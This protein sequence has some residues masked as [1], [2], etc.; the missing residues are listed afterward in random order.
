MRYVWRTRGPDHR[1][2]VSGGSELLIFVRPE[3]SDRSQPP[4]VN[5]WLRVAAE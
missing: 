1:A 2:A 3:A 4:P 5:A